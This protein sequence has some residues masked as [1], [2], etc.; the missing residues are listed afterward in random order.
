[1]IKKYFGTKEFYKM[2]LLIAVPIIVQNGFTNLV[3]LL[4]NMMVGRVGTDQMSGV[5]IV[6]QLLFV[7]NLSVFGGLSGAGLFSAQYYG[8]QNKEGIRNVFRVKLIIVAVILTVGISVLVLL[9]TP[10]IQLSLHEGSETGDPVATMNYAQQY[11]KIML[12]GLLPFSI[13]QCYGSTLRE[14]GETVAPMKAGILAVLVN[15]SLNYLLI[16]GKLGFPVMGVRGAAIATT[17]SRF[18]ECIAIVIWTHRH[19]DKHSFAKG[20]MRNFRVPPALVESIM[21]KGMPLLLN[22]FVWS[23][24]MTILSQCY[25][26]RGLAVV[27]GNNIGSTLNNLFSVVFI[28]L[29]MSVS[30]VV[31]NLLGSGDMEKARDTDTKMFVF[32]ILSSFVM[33][34]LMAVVAPFFPLIYNTTDEARLIATKIIWIMALMA[35]LD[36]FNNAAYFTLRSGGKTWITFLFDSCFMCLTSIPVAFLLARFTTMSII[37]LYFIS[38]FI[39]MLKCVVGYFFVRSDVWMHNIV[40]GLPTETEPES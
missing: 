3:N 15:L 17:I 10:L 30:I 8:A 26:M 37:P 36:A 28:A 31:G 9:R 21:R 6:N 39:R 12:I 16:Y 23:A 11:L 20:A 29:G 40:E 1:M 22:E 24:G 33:A 14:T 32:A 25:S 2:V 5:A 35:P 18:A 34:G 7:F 4:D 13:S 38:Q 19:S 27:A